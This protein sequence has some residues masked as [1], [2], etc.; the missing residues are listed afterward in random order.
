MLDILLT[1][2]L[3]RALKPGTRLLLIGD[4]DQL[5]SVGAGNVLGDIIRSDRFNT[6][7]LR[8]IF[9]QASASL[10]IT[11]AHCI[12]QGDYPDLDVKDNDFFFIQRDTAEEIASTVC[13]LCTT[14]LPQLLR[15][16]DAV[17]DT[18]HCTVPKGERGH[19][20]S[21]CAASARTKSADAVEERTKIPRR[22]LSRGRQGH[23]DKEQL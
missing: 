8:E 3:C 9:R 20:E 4:S 17:E 14:R 10:I 21:E 2:A 16:G 22:C 13:A 5:P 12:N 19:C 15:R 6:V 18:G 23:A 11:N 7:R 1:E